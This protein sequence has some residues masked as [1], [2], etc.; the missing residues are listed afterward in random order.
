VTLSAGA[1]DATLRRED[2]VLLLQYRDG[3]R[4]LVDIDGSWLQVLPE[5]WRKGDE[6]ARRL[7]AF[8]PPELHVP[9]PE[10]LANDD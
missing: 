3:G 9:I 4:V 10:K 5:G 8:V 2:V 7:D 1:D 6:L